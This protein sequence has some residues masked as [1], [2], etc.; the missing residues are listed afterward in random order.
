MLPT[1]KGEAKAD[2]LNWLGTAHAA[3]Q[4]DAV[5]AAMNDTD[6]EV[7]A[8]AVAAASKIGGEKALAA[9]VARP[10]ACRSPQMVA[11]RLPWGHSWPR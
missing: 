5:A 3:S 7:V 6:A 10:R 8:S 9:L 1:L 2:V 11:M 4:I